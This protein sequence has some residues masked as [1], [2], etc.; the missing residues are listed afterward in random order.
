MNVPMIE[1]N[2]TKV[3]QCDHYNM[4]RE[5]YKTTLKVP[6]VPT[7]KAITVSKSAK[8]TR[9]TDDYYS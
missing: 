5:K 7:R 8:T 1:I 4:L 6:L 2:P 3:L 9:R